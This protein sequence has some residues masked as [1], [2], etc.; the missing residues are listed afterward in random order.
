MA[1]LRLAMR[2]GEGGLTLV[3]WR[4]ICLPLFSFSASA[5]GGERAFKRLHQVHTTRRNRL[6]SQL[7]DRLTRFAFNNA[8]LRSLDPVTSFSSSSN[9]LRLRRFCVPEGYVVNGG[10]V[11]VGW[12]AE[13]G[14]GV[15]AGVYANT[16]LAAAADDTADD[17]GGTGLD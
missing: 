15:A 17:T 7:V 12:A 5:A 13:G 8:Q 9:E 10:G 4:P 3:I 14:V 2:D 11:R 6:F 16:V 1:D